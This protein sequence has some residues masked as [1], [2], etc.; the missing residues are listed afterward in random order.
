[1]IFFGSGMDFCDGFHFFPAT[2]TFFVLEDTDENRPV[3]LNEFEKFE[4]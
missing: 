3:K 1:M 4:S 2:W